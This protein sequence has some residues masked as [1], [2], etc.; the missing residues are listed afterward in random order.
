MDRKLIIDV[1]VHKGEDTEYYLKKGFRVVGIEAN[2][3]LYQSTK[4][5]LESYINTGQLKLLNVAISPEDGEIIFY[6]NLDR[7]IWGTIFPDW[8]KRNEILGT[9]SVGIKVKSCRF[10]KILQ[11]F[12]VP[13]YLKVDIE[14]ADILCVRA[15]QNFQ[16][17]P[18]FISLESTKTSW[19]DLLTEFHLLK[20][21]GYSKFKVINQ[22][23][24]SEQTCPYP[25]KEGEYIKHKFEYGCSGLFGEETPGNWLSENQAIGLYKWVFWFYKILGI[26]GIIYKYPLGKMIIEGI[27]LKEPWYDTHATF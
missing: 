17:K 14:G 13:Y 20:Q 6:T 8:V 27:N 12:G 18:R 10:E 16:T 15:L 26:Q 21:L 1:G 24:V 5:R 4:D 11:E 9:K 3:D 23:K 7:S 22:S 25:A 2:P 19:S